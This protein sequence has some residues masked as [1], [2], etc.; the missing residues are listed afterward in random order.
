MSLART[1]LAATLLAVLLATAPISAEEAR[2]GIDWP[3]FR[4]IRASGVAEGFPTA[5]SFDVASGAN[6]KWRSEIAGLAHSSPVIW[7]NDLCLTTAVSAEGTPELKVGLYGDIGSAADIGPQRYEVLC[8][9]K[10][11]GKERWRTTAYEGA[12]KTKRHPKATHANSTPATDGRH[13]VTFFGS[14]GFYCHDLAGKLLWKKDFGVLDAGYYLAPDAQWGFASSP[15]IHD[16]KVIV[17]VDVLQKG[18]FIAAFDVATGNEVWRVGRTD[19]PT[20]STPT[21]WPLGAGASGGSTTLVLANGYRQIG[22]YDFATGREVWRMTGGG[23]IPVPTPI[24]AHDLAFITNAHGR[25]APVYAVRAGASGDITLATG[26]TSN[27]GLAWSTAR[28]GAYMQ[29]PIVYG[30]LL[31]VGRDNGVVTCFDARTGA[32]KYQTRIGDGSRGFTSSPVAA[33]GKIYFTSEQG[34][35]VVVR[36]GAEYQEL[37]R[38]ELGEVHMSTPAISEG[39]LYFR[40]RGHVVAIAESA[41]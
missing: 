29:T 19:V 14:E 41:K 1:S 18:G 10:T 27:A 23:D 13:L 40:T 34:D 39:V 37:A 38:N 28:D 31:Y 9:D 3:G 6:V 12:P 36:A 4:G 7:G 33:D 8:L 5:A 32:Q 20:W 21:V 15:V 11:T 26:A 35:V 25:M 22:A 16:G 17:Q 30:D 2:P 24:T